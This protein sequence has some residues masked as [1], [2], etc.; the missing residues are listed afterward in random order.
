MTSAVVL[1]SGVFDKLFLDEDD[2]GEF[3]RF[4]QF[5]REKKLRLIAPSLF[6]YEVLAVAAA[7]PF[8]ATAAHDLIQAFVKAGFSLVELDGPVIVKAI[9]IANFGHQKSGFPTFYD[10][11][12]QALALREGGVF[13]TADQKHAT[14][15][16][17]FG[18]IVLL[19]DREAHF[20]R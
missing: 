16:T 17:R 8:G 11:S 19:R 5:A 9:E 3:V 15:T 14:K 6:L 2:R 12:Y 18:G 10:L 4:L 1:D 7:T 13:L 20:L